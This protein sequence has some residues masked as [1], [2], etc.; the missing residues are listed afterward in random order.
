MAEDGKTDMSKYEN[1]FF[2]HS[3][4][5]YNRVL[6]PTLEEVFKETFTGPDFSDRNITILDLGCGTGRFRKDIES[7]GYKWIGLD[8]TK[9]G[10]G[11]IT[12]LGDS[13]FLPF[14]NDAF[15]CVFSKCTLEH[16]NDPKTVMSEVH[17]VLK[18][19][20]FFV[21]EVSFLEPFHKSYFNFSHWG[22]EHML[23]N[24][25][26]SDV[27]I[28]TGRT[29]WTLLLKYIFMENEKLM[30]LSDSLI[31]LIIKP[32]I[33]LTKLLV[34]GFKRIK[35][36][37]NS[38]EYMEAADYYNNKLPFILAGTFFFMARKPKEMSVMK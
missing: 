26:F 22:L 20:A 30:R 24:A 31:K 11:D 32:F 14:R 3:V 16:F 12:V 17:R 18:R 5:Y 4:Q 23:H 15:D 27:R 33:F 6:L 19:Q 36:G 1:K 28:R 10:D 21:G 29:V 38:G 25:G 34:C 7:F 9:T 35:H 13:H 37:K 2:D 8:I